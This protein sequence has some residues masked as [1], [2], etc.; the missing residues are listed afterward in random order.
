MRLS[1]TSVVSLSSASV[2]PTNTRR[3]TL[4]SNRC[5][6]RLVPIIDRAL[7]VG[8]ADAGISGFNLA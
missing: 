6:F 2:F 5:G 3:N 8:G 4:A 7:S 1:C